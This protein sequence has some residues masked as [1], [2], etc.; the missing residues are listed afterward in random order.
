MWWW[1][2]GLPR[3][4]WRGRVASH[5]KGWESLTPSPKKAGEML[6]ARGGLWGLSK[7]QKWTRRP[8]ARRKG[9]PAGADQVAAEE[10]GSGCAT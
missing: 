4:G 9:R 8:I 3:V 5:V 7:L 2:K 1:G 10:A 6:R